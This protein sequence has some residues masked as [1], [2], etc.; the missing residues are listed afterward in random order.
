MNTQKS[1]DCG[2]CKYIKIEESRLNKKKMG[3]KNSPMLFVHM[4]KNMLQAKRAKVGPLIILLL[5]L[6][7]GPC[8]LNR[9]VSFV[10]E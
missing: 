8:I 9:L 4:L 6:T 2:V 3:N 1:K 10:R 5:L 7:L